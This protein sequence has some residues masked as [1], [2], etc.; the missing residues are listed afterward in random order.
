[1]PSPLPLPDALPISPADPRFSDPLSGLYWQVSG[2]SGQMLRSRSLWDM[3]LTLPADALPA[4]DTHIH[5]LWGPAHTRLLV[6][7]R[8]IVLSDRKSTRLNS[9]HVK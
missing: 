4:G 5:E 8:S 2:A 9:S 1:P 7:E 3:T 6:A